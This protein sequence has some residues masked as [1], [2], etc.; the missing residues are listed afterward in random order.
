MNIIRQWFKDGGPNGTD[1]DAWIDVF[2]RTPTPPEIVGTEVWIGRLQGFSYDDKKSHWFGPVC[3][4]VKVQEP[5]DDIYPIHRAAISV[6]M[7]A[8]IQDDLQL[9]PGC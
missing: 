7:I 3:L 9:I 6:L 4:G 1:H 5:A 8:A 2:V